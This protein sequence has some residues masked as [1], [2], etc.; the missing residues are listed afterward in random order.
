MTKP[1]LAAL[2]WD[3]APIEAETV[4]AFLTQLG[5]DNP[6]DLVAF[7]LH[8]ARYGDATEREASEGGQ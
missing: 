8:V 3:D 1:E 7:R 4:A 6:D 5:K 2:V